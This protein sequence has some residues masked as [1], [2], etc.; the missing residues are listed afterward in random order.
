M[1]AAQE[2]GQFISPAFEKPREN[3]SPLVRRGVSREF[4]RANLLPVRFK[5]IADN[6]TVVRISFS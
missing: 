6:G 3:R 5:L 4:P 1:Y 2:R